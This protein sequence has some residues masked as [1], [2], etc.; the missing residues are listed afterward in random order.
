MQDFLTVFEGL[1]YWGPGC[2]DETRKAFESLNFSPK[3]ILEIGCGNGNAT[4]QLAKLSD[5]Q[6]IANNNE[7]SA[8]DRLG[9]RIQSLGLNN[10]IT[11]RCISMTELDFAEHSFDVIRAEASM[12]VMGVESALSAWKALLKPN[13]FLVFSDL[14]WLTDSPSQEA[15]DF[16]MGDYP[17]MQTLNVRK[18]QIENSGYSIKNTFPISER[19][20]RNYYA[21]LQNRILEV[22]NRIK[23]SQAIADFQRKLY[24]YQRYL[25][26]FGYQFFVAQ[27]KT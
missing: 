13:G 17:D 9:Q 7:Q 18:L 21:P 25:G 6:I 16:W 22:Q 1:E 23:G 4:L 3:N 19:A 26:E 15:V 5:T 2:K 11:T 10:R 20:W 14:V 8:L 24:L 27:K 12:Y